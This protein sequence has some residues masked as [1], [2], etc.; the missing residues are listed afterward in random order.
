MPGRIGPGGC[1][2]GCMPC[3]GGICMRRAGCPG[4]NGLFG[5]TVGGG[6]GGS[7]RFTVSAR[8]ALISYLARYLTNFSGGSSLFTDIDLRVVCE[9]VVEGIVNSTCTYS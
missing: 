3:W 4:G 8:S 9:T 7:S 2:G 5:G 6:G 1:I